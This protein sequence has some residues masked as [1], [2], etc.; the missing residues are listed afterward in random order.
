MSDNI[1][2]ALSKFFT[3]RSKP[4]NER[5]PGSYRSLV[6][7]TND[8]LCMGRIRFKCPELHDHSNLVEDCPWAVP[9]TDLGG[10]NT[11]RFTHPCI[12]DFVWITF[13]KQHPYG[14]IWT[15]FATPTRR[16]FYTHEQISQKTPISLNDTGKTDTKVV[17][18]DTDYL[19]KDGR[20][21]AHG[22]RDRYGNCDIHS[23]VGFFPKEHNAKPPP[24]DHDAVQGSAFN[25]QQTKP[26]VNSPDKK[27]MARVTKYG[28][29]SIQSDQGY[30][31][32]K[33][34]EFGEF[35]GDYAKDEQ[36]EIKRW[37]YL[38]KLLN[39]GSPTG[40]KRRY[41]EKT[42]Y[43]H[44][45]EMRDTGWA[46][47]GPIAS[48]SR[49]GEYGE[50][51]TLSKEAVNDFRWVKLRTKGGMLMQACDKGFDP[52]NDAYIKR[53]LL[54]ECGEKSEMEDKYWGGDRDARWYRVFTRYGIKLVLDDRGSDQIEAHKRES[55]RG[56][57]FLIKGRRS[58]GSGLKDSTGNPRGYQF[59]FNENDA[60]NH[61]SWMSPLGQ[62]IE[63]ND[64][65]QYLMMTGSLGKGWVPKW[66][67]LAE[68]EFVRKPT[69]I[70]DPE[71]STHHLKIDHQNE[72]IRFKTR[73]GGGAAPDEIVNP[74]GIGAAELNQGVEARDGQ[75]GAGPWVEI[76]DSQHRG[77]W[78]SKKEQ[79][80]VW[81][82]KKG[83][84]ILQLLDDKTKTIVIYNGGANGTI[85]IYSANDLKITS[86][87]SLQLQAAENI[88]MRAKSIRMHSEGGAKLTVANDVSTNATIKADVVT[89]FL[90]GA[91][92]GPG[93]GTNSPGGQAVSKHNPP[94]IPS[95]IEPN[96]RGE[97]YNGPF[98]ECPIEE[99]EHS[100]RKN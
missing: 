5:F 85:H 30:Q 8:P 64:R 18:Y 45:F 29:I 81:R 11:G 54:E 59:E 2:L 13:E 68:N 49:A 19:P 9:A 25:Q 78:F 36:F 27:Y 76:V 34:G 86:G 50:A 73:G 77:M 31:W 93:A 43:G 21:M 66:R 70:R 17:D 37:L 41:E 83:S 12:G 16:R 92:P 71:I 38:Q 87:G 82:G 1:H 48:K 91:M 94:T 79:L 65:Y 20:P 89:A 24:A 39:E 60:A 33:D 46:Q 6:V 35:D 10:P 58:P 52:Q 84:N 40:D 56:N 99:V 80:G 97:T 7:E 55:P 96:D 42:R 44:R 47:S 57:G 75:N 32:K 100:I 15:G 72:Y 22:W 51:R 53:N 88:T 63:I 4:L 14:P 69:M 98:E 28:Q 23:S 90:T 67:G 26:E 61:T 3:E 74:T 95:I 62:V